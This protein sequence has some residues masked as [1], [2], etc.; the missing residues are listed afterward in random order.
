MKALGL[1][2]DK[3]QGEN[4]G[5]P[6]NIFGTLRGISICASEHDAKL[7]LRRIRRRLTALIQKPKPQKNQNK[8]Q[9]FVKNLCLDIF[10]TNR[11]LTICLI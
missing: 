7:S 5:I 10:Y 2:P 6:T 8:F 11:K 3:S 4:D 9:L 1:D